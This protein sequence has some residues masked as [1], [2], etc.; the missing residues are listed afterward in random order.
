MNSKCEMAIQKYCRKSAFGCCD[1][2]DKDVEVCPYLKAISEISRLTL[3]N[4]ILETKFS[5]DGK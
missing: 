5:D 3:E 2:E 4:N 1:A